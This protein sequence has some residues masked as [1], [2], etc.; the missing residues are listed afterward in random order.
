MSAKPFL[1]AYFL[2]MEYLTDNKENYRIV[3]VLSY[4]LSFMFWHVK[5]IYYDKKIYSILYEILF[6]KF[7][8]KNK[9][10]TSWLLDFFYNEKS[11]FL[12]Y[13]GFQLQRKMF[14]VVKCNDRQF[15][16]QSACTV[17]I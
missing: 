2:R 12:S 16:L 6:V 5:Y 13:V 3:R 15:Q 9:L 8:I 10:L 11:E 1:L 7:S 14:E 4:Y 17:S